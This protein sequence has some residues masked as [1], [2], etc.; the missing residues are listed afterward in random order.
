MHP[1]ASSSL[2]DKIKELN[3]A[4]YSHVFV[5]LLQQFSLLQSHCVKRV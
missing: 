5:H 2:E 4:Y 3:V 1:M